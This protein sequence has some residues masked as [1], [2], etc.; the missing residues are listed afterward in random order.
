MITNQ[1]ALRNLG[2]FSLLLI[3][4]LL[5]KSWTDAPFHVRD[6]TPAERIEAWRQQNA[7]DARAQN[8]VENIKPHVAR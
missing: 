7:E 6:G 4:F 8:Y 3:A 5:F 1:K 2:V